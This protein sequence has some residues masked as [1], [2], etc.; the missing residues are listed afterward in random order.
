MP[1]FFHETRAGQR[2]SGLVSVQKEKKKQNK[3]KKD[4]EIDH[5]WFFTKL[6]S[7]AYSI[8]ITLLN[9]YDSLPRRLSSKIGSLFVNIN[10]ST[11]QP[12]GW[13]SFVRVFSRWIIFL[14]KGESSNSDSQNASFLTLFSRVLRNSTSRFVGPSV[15]PSHLIWFFF[16]GLWT[17]CSCPNDQV[18]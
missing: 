18:T 10:Q 12:I 16:C 13:P 17:H 15:R 11:S 8:L 7:P 3:K 9:L 1:A 4:L 14:L 2:V 6:M 5:F